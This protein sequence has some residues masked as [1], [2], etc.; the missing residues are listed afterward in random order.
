MAMTQRRISSE[1]RLPH[2][3]ILDECEFTWVQGCCAQGW[4]SQGHGDYITMSIR[5]INF[6]FKNYPLQAPVCYVNLN[7]NLMDLLCNIPIDIWSWRLLA[8]IYPE[9][10][11]YVKENDICLCC[12]SCL[13]N[14]N[15]SRR[16]D[17]L[18]KECLL[19]ASISKLGRTRIYHG[20]QYLKMIFERFP[21]EII[22]HMIDLNSH[23]RIHHPYPHCTSTA[24]R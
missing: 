1:L 12:S 20:G 22:T 13:N 10:K 3:K 6:R 5:F 8:F 21:D 19:L 7:N 16:L 9:Y 18:V 17:D 24:I 2:D 14:W 4:R 11:E 15:I 23:W